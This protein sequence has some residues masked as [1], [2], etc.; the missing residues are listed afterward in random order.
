MPNLSL[1]ELT[2]LTDR[3]GYSSTSLLLNNNPL[4]LIKHPTSHLLLDSMAMITRKLALL[5]PPDNVPDI[6][7]LT[8]PAKLLRSY[9]V[10]E[11]PNDPA[12]EKVCKDL[13]GV[14]ALR[15]AG[16][17]RPSVKLGQ[18]RQQPG[19]EALLVYKNTGGGATTKAN[20]ITPQVKMGSK[21]QIKLDKQT[22]SLIKFQT[23]SIS[24]E[25]WLNKAAWDEI[26]R[27][28]SEK[29]AINAW[30][31]HLVRVWAAFHPKAPFKA[32]GSRTEGGPDCTPAKASH[33]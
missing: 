13:G 3:S 18:S 17:D 25:L 15:D 22:T 31:R 6:N 21:A 26:R 28:F 32:T 9:T 24:L 16:T 11:G 19:V 30:K 7:N 23:A 20:A 33:G 4:E 8:D 12:I 27:R 10:A 5:I 2:K 1:A 14:S 29:E